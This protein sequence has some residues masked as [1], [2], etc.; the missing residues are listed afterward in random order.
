MDR[1]PSES[2][3]A[4]IETLPARSILRI[5]HLPD[6]RIEHLHPAPRPRGSNTCPVSGGA[7]RT[8]PVRSIPW[9]ET[10]RSRR[11]RGSTLFRPDPCRGSTP[12]R[13]PGARIDTP[14]IRSIRRIEH[15]RGARIEHLR[16]RAECES[17]TCTLPHA[18]GS[19]TCAG[20]ET[21]DRTPPEALDPVDRD[22]S[23]SPDARTDTLRGRRARGSRP[24]RSAR[25]CGSNT[26]R[27]HGSNTCAGVGDANRTL[28]PC[29]TPA[30]I[31]TLPA[32]ANRRIEHLPD[33][34]IEHLRGRRGL[35][36]NRSGLLDVVDRDPSESPDPRIDTLPARSMPWIDTLAGAGRADRD[37]SGPRDPAD[38]TLAGRVDRTLARPPWARI[39]QFRSARCRG[40]NTCAV[41][42]NADRDPS[43]PLH[44]ADRHPSRSP[45]RRSTPFTVAGS[46]PFGGH[47]KAR[48]DTPWPARSRRSR[49]FAVI[50]ARI[51]ALH[52]RRPA[53]I[54]AVVRRDCGLHGATCRLAAPTR[55]DY[56]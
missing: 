56:T 22:P 23:E 1:D 15:L 29:S 16:G 11:T 12:S 30:R 31:E 53:R 28:A 42:G 20:A 4:R 38:R 2:P 39:E 44:A 18:R 8:D 32:R 9:I 36:S 10:L 25:S 13:A 50:G 48:I 3:G 26:C 6:A 33:A 7:D 54:R 52:G 49:S 35:G 47:R 51:D 41:V 21:A 55:F 40:S 27:T 37:P 14:P 5:E 17:N 19:N 46:T 34:R 24:F 43:S 45:G